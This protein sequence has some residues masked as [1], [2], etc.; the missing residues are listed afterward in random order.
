MPQDKSYNQG[1]MNDNNA[2]CMVVVNRSCN[3]GGITVHTYCCPHILLSTPITVL[4]GNTPRFIKR[5][6]PDCTATAVPSR[7][8]RHHAGQ[9]LGKLHAREL[10]M[11]PDSGSGAAVGGAAVRGL[12][13]WLLRVL[14]G[15]PWGRGLTHPDPRRV[16][17]DSTSMRSQVEGCIGKIVG[18]KN[19][20]C[21][22]INTEPGAAWNDLTS[23]P[24][25]RPA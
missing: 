22:K 9:I 24:A 18:Q 11:C 21:A 25:I 2:D 17:S 13:G 6:L 10:L 15:I 14:K 1:Q 19:I 12:R 20:G 4:T 23:P 5:Q 7:I 3:S 8:P 16:Q